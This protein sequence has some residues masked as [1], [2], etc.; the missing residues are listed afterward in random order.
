MKASIKKTPIVLQMEAVECGAACLAMILAYYKKIVPLEQLRTD[1]GVSRDGSKASNLLRAARKYGL[2]AKGFRLK[3]ETLWDK[4]FP[5]VIFWNFNHFVVL[6]GRKGDKIYLNDPGAGRR[7]VSLEEFDSSF[8]GIALIF[9]KSKTFQPSGFKPSGL[10]IIKEKLKNEKKA[11][12]YTI[13]AGVLLVVPNLV[14]PIISRFYVD[15]ILVGK[16]MNLFKPMLLTMGVA[17]LLKLILTWLQEHHL[18]KFETKLSLSGSS[19]FL[20]HLFKLPMSFFDQRMPGELARR[21][22]A[23][24]SIAVMLSGN[25]ASISISLLTLILFVVLMMQIDVVLTLLC[26]LSLGISILSLVSISE[27]RKMS[28][29]I[30]QQEYGKLIGTFM[31]DIQMIETLKSTGKE[32]EAFETWAGQQAKMIKAQ[33]NMAIIDHVTQTLPFILKKLLNVSILAVGSYRV[34]NGN[35]TVGLIVAFQAFAASY[36]SPIQLLMDMGSSFQKTMAD[37]QRINDV[38]A[39]PAIEQPNEDAL[40]KKLRGE[41][42]LKNISFGYSPLE[43]PLIESFS[44][45]ITPGARIALVG[46]SGSGKST[47]SKILAGLYFPGKGEILYDNEPLSRLSKKTFACSVSKVDQEILMFSGTI[48]D[49]LTLWDS[50]I[51]EENIIK[52]AKDAC[53]HDVISA[54]PNGYYSLVEESGGNFSGGQRQRLEIARALATN[55]SILILDEATSALDPVTEK[56]IDDN[57]RRRGCSCIIIAHRLSTIRDCDEII[58]MNRGEIVQRGTHEELISQEGHY[59]EL[60]KS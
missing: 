59:S 52:A 39:Y 7:T 20:Y 24:D 13:L 22:Q 31:S 47:V 38:M 50:T 56:E 9:S 14:I 11:V 10:Q 26:L 49:N 16:V 33:Q 4:E 8:T 57:I 35:L 40:L 23:N 12:F 21:I 46:G 53:I 42:E 34:M 55:P 44:L 32:S 58:V 29:L 28:S 5:A 51:S 1:C 19:Q 2:E 17:A 3:M 54:R 60:I 43:E 25:F 30:Y 15:R 41:V 36:I 6:E 48:M 37:I 18:L 27:K 45:K